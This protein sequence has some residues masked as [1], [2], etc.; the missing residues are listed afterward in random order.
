MEKRFL[1]LTAYQWLWILWV[2]VALFTCQLKYFKHIDNNYLIFRQ[3]YYHA[4]AQTNLYAAYPK[5]YGDFY[6][7]QFCIY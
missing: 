4:R 3:A 7:F 6:Y 1:R 5:E 2:A